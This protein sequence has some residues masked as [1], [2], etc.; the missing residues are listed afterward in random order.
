MGSKCADSLGM[1]TKTDSGLTGT[2]DQELVDLYA[3]H[4]P[5]A[6]ITEMTDN[7]IHHASVAA[8]ALE[9]RGYIEQAGIWLHDIRPALQA[10]T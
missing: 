1:E 10:T 9:C 4:A 7:Q 3:T 8:Y 5:S 2:T 6:A